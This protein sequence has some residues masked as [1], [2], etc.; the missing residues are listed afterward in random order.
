MAERQLHKG[1]GA[2]SNREGRFES[3]SHE[4][5]DDGWALEEEPAA[6]LETRVRPDPARSIIS[7]NDSPDVGFDRSINPY[8]GCEH[9]CIYC[10]ARP[11]HSY[12]SLSPGLDFESRL[13]FKENASGLLE[14]ALRKPGYRPALIS[15]GANTDAYQPIEREYRVTRAV[16]EVLLRFRHPASLVTKSALV[17]RD[18]DL[19]SEMAQERL[20]AVGVS[21][22]SLD[23]ALKRTLEPRAASARARPVLT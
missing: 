15:I 22:T 7:Y 11:S 23:P 17:L 4:A 18:L 21:L 14:A 3:R 12:L 9:G 16:L 5:F 1:R 6:R 19:L 13:F 8:R 20:I 10:Y 2:T